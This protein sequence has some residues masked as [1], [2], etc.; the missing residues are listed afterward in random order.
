VLSRD[1]AGLDVLAKA[2]S[3]APW[4]PLLPAAERVWTDDHASILPYVR[5]GRLL[6]KH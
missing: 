6:K 2:R 5:W 4:R 3:D 1:K